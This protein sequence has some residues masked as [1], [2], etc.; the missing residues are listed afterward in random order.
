MKNNIFT[1]FIGIITVIFFSGCS[2][3][4]EISVTVDTNSDFSKYRTFAWISD[5]M[6]TTNSPYNNE[7]IR[8][9]IR[10]YFGHSFSERGYRID[11]DTPDVLLQLV[12]V[13]NKKEK[14]VIYPTYPRNYY[15]CP[16]YYCSDYYSPYSFDYYYRYQ[17]EYC[18]PF[19]YCKDKVEYVEGSITL[20]V[21]DR[22]QN[23]L[24]WS[25]T[26]K[27]D[28][29]DPAYIHQNIHPAVRSIMRK[30][31]VKTVSEDL[32]K[33]KKNSDSEEKPITQK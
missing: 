5:D 2:L 17:G 15:Y 9:N 31:P 24:V 33:K 13:S 32:K 25:G 6:D 19:G 21:I 1:R 11:L 10:N 20:N 29:Y 28:I 4:T 18:Y 16:Y 30:Y 23:K 26:A 14:E 27:G 3:Y 12:I 8:N 22:K 7:I